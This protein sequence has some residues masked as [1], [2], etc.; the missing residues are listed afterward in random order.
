MLFRS[1][2]RKDSHILNQFLSRQSLPP[3][4]EGNNLWRHHSKQEPLRFPQPLLF[5]ALLWNIQMQGNPSTERYG[6]QRGGQ[7]PPGSSTI[8]LG[9]PG[10][11]TAV[12]RA[13]VA[14][15]IDH[16]NRIVYI[17]S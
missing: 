12:E 16:I 10:R 1:L 9:L 7:D 2:T 15:G 6:D 8:G 4:N 17:S 5:G 3:S 13:A 14:E 11:Q